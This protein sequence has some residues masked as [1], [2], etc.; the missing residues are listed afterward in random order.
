MRRSLNLR[1]CFPPALPA[2]ARNRPAAHGR[3]PRQ[4]GQSRLF[5]RDTRVNQRRNSGLDHAADIQSQT[6][7]ENPSRGFVAACCVRDKFQPS[8]QKQISPL[9]FPGTNK[10]RYAGRGNHRS[11]ANTKRFSNGAVAHVRVGLILRKPVKIAPVA[12]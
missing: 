5:M 9:P 11:A 3:F 2:P 6:G 7:P 1:P 10:T 8:L 4:S 12:Y